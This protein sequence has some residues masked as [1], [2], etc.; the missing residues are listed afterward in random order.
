MWAGSY[1]GVPIKPRL[2]RSYQ[3]EASF[4]IL[5]MKWKGPDRASERSGESSKIPVMKWR[6]R[7]FF[8]GQVLTARSPSFHI[9][10][11]IRQDGGITNIISI[12][13]RPAWMQS[14]R[15]FA[16]LKIL[17]H[18]S[19][20]CIPNTDDDRPILSKRIPKMYNANR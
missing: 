9:T 1:V 13:K 12:F 10:R 2:R 18:H 7:R 19:H 4:R 3:C 14:R 17:L 20:S 5:E 16:S 15:R 6:G 11:R 8:R